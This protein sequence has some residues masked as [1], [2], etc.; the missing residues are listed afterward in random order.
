[1]ENEE[2]MCALKGLEIKKKIIVCVGE[3]DG[4]FY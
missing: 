4:S 2:G 1:L 3:E